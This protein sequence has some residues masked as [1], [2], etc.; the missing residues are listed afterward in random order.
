MQK[1]QEQVEREVA[2]EFWIE[3]Y[4][5]TGDLT[6]RNKLWKQSKRICYRAMNRFSLYLNRGD[7]WFDEYDH[8]TIVAFEHALKM[9][10]KEKG[11]RWGTWLV[12]TIRSK[13]SGTTRILARRSDRYL[14]EIN[15]IENKEHDNILYQYN[16]SKFSDP[17]DYAEE[18]IWECDRRDFISCLDDIDQEIIQRILEKENMSEIGRSLKKPYTDIRKRCLKIGQLY[19]EYMSG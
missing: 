4:Q 7:D 16:W 1:T 10:R 11:I 3:K 14:P 6:Y 19:K 15:N 2:Y 18:V 9:F 8:Y 13:M 12:W 17:R 5:E